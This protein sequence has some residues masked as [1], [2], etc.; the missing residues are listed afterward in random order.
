[1]RDFPEPLKGA[2]SEEYVDRALESS[3]RCTLY[4]SQIAIIQTLSPCPRLGSMLS[5]SYLGSQT[6][7][8]GKSATR[9]GSILDMNR[10]ISKI[11]LTQFWRFIW[12]ICPA[13]DRSRL[14][15]SK[16][17]LRYKGSGFQL[18][19]LPCRTLL[20]FPV[21]FF[22]LLSTN[23]PTTGTFPHEWSV[24]RFQWLDVIE[25]Q[26]GDSFRPRTSITSSATIR[27]HFCRCITNDLSWMQRAAS[28]I[29]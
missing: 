4:N 15:Q 28:R 21:L 29:D 13:E 11:T 1:M 17:N 8:S 24:G 20:Y 26:T 9:L 6:S 12:W 10:W 19:F 14:P 2:L 18:S 27:G 16:V 3:P 5:L 22:N 25:Q 23:P 7:T